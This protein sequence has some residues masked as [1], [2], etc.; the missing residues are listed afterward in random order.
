[1]EPVERVEAEAESIEAPNTLPDEPKEGEERK[2]ETGGFQESQATE[3][4]PPKALNVEEEA[5]TFLALFADNPERQAYWKERKEAGFSYAEKHAR[6]AREA[7]EQK[8]VVL[9]EMRRMELGARAEAFEKTLPKSMTR[10]EKG[11]AFNEFVFEQI[12]ILGITD[13]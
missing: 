7:E 4:V 3:A 2:E 9:D 5:E 6:S 13:F 10:D 12:E 11:R 8:R 1:M